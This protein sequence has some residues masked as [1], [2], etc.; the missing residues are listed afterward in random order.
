M[1]CTRKP[2]WMKGQVEFR[3]EYLWDIRVA[4][5]NDEYKYFRKE[6]LIPRP[7]DKGDGIHWRLIVWIKT[8]GTAKVLE[9][10]S[11]RP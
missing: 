4:G 6:T 1:R 11:P 5:E 9:R 3:G 7:T 8:G 10:S 2:R